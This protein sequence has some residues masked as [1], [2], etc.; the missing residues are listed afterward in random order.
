MMAAKCPLQ[1]RG[2][3]VGALASLVVA[4]FVLVPAGSLACKTPYLTEFSPDGTWRLDVCSR[5]RMFAMPG[6]GSDAPGWIV[7][8]DGQG[9]IRGVAALAM[10]QLYGDTSSP[11]EWSERKVSR[12]MVF[13]LAIEPAESTFARWW[14]ER[15]WRWRAHLGLTSSDEELR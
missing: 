3:I 8:R 11:T 6:S 15:L 13:E 5:P 10:L 12:S 7:L 9:G 14:D 4:I 1:R 2:A